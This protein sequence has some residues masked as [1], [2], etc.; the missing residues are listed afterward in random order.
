MVMP[1]NMLNMIMNLYRKLFPLFD[2]SKVSFGV[3]YGSYEASE[4]E[5]RFLS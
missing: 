4:C 5:E 1:P 2:L 3:R